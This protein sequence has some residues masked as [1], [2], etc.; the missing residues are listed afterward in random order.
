MSETQVAQDEFLADTAS[1]LVGEA[2]E[3]QGGANEGD[4]S[5]EATE[6]SEA[7]SEGLPDLNLDREVPEDIL[8][9][10]EKATLDFGEDEEPEELEVPPEQEWEDQDTRKLR[11]ELAK[12]QKRMEFL[13]KQNARTG[14]KVWAEEAREYFPLAEESLDTIEATSRRAYLKRAQEI[15]NQLLPSYKRMK[16]TLEERLE[17]EREKTR[18]ETRRELEEAW[19]RPTVVG[20]TSGP[21]TADLDDRRMRFRTHQRPS[22]VDQISKRFTARG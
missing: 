13:E 16:K 1:A 12:A 5:S 21:D 22:L 15:H 19:G 14:K 20:D 2:S 11:A 8:S 3:A 18:V 9:E 10:I 17:S 4:S 7:A 6:A